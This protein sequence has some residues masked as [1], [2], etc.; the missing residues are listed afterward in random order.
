MICIKCKEKIPIISNLDFE[1]GNITL[2][3][4]CDNEN[5]DYLIKNYLEELNKIK[6]EINE[7]N[8]KRQSCFIHKN[9]NIEL[10]CLDCSKELCYDCDLKIHQKENHQLCKLKLFFD[11]IEKN[12][13]YYSVIHDELIYFSKFNQKYINEIIK[14]IEYTYISFYQ[15]KNKKEI[16]YTPLKNTCYIELR[17]FEYDKNKD[18][19][20]NDNNFNDNNEKNPQKKNN[21]MFT[22]EINSIRIYS[23][24]KK[25]ELSTQ[26]HKKGKSISFF[27]ILLIPNSNYC[28][29]I[30]SDNK[31]LLLDIKI[32]INDNENN[33]EKNIIASREL[34]PKVISSI[35]NLSLLNEEIFSIIYTS[36]SFD[37]FFIKKNEKIELIKKKYTSLANSTNI[38]NQ[39]KLSKE[40]NKIII[41]INNKIKFFKY[42]NN[43]IDENKIFINEID[44]NNL[45][46]IM[47]LNFHNSFLS[48]FNNNE[49]IIKDKIDKK[50]YIID[51]K[52]KNISFIYEI[53]SMNFLATINFDN[54]INIFDM[55]L[56]VNKTKLIGH[57]SI[58]N[59]IKEIV[60]LNNSNYNTKLISCSDDGTVR[61]WDM[62]KFICELSIQLDKGGIL[63]NINI[64][65]NK[66]IMALTN[67]NLIYIIE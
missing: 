15:Q 45:T 14:F 9:N 17:I 57:K 36:G 18:Y 25:I 4:Q 55:N 56:M 42:N 54:N 13:K 20:K 29:L 19:I 51:I 32:N 34:N 10:F 52:G 31:L 8:I 50:N 58:I 40:K 65:P 37:L 6:E 30:S 59:D 62:I 41:L 53:K 48:L 11:M 38:I 24:I 67:E 7:N 5:E 33:L 2:Y 21:N 28:I 63:C 47:D 12:I 64:L 22:K 61:I 26:S 44:R 16:N 35:Y 43:D 60:P 23:K 1:K 66:E 49:I 39:I 46:L 3:C 27:N